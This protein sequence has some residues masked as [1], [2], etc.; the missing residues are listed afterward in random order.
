MNERDPEQATQAEVHE[1]AAGT[2][3]D[4]TTRR[5]ALET[6]LMDEGASEAGEEIGDPTP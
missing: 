4:S 6:E 1:E 3:D 5:E 2:E